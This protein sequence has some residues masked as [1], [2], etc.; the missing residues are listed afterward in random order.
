LAAWLSGNLTFP[1]NGP[2]ILAL[3][4]VAAGIL[5]HRTW[6]F[7]ITDPAAFKSLH[8]EM[9]GRLSAQTVRQAPDTFH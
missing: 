1:F 2:F 8:P 6:D 3:H 4:R 5:G 7:V 9:D